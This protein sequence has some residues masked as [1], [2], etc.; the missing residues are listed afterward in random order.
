MS[1]DPARLA[2]LR[3]TSR[4]SGHERQTSLARASKRAR[5]LLK[6]AAKVKGGESVAR[7]AEIGGEL[8][9]KTIAGRLRVV[10]STIGCPLWL[11]LLP[12]QD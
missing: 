1:C 6:A 3:G 2:V 12:M 9:S 8:A 11:I 4:P 10:A 7:A 5:K